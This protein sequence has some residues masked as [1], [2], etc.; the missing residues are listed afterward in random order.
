M[1][2]STLD[3]VWPNLSDCGPETEQY[4]LIVYIYSF[5]SERK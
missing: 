3:Q 4:V 2:Y 5:S 1:D